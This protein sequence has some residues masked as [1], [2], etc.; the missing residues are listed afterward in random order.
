MDLYPAI[1]LLDGRC[2][3]LYQGDY[4]RSTVYGDDPVAQAL[5]FQSEGAPWVHVVDL[6]AAR[7]GEP[8][9]R[10]VVAAIAGALDVP[11]QTGGGVRTVEAAE[12]LFS[13][14]VAR[15]V[16]GTAALEDPDLVRR[17]AADHPVA[18]GLDARGSEVAVRGWLEGSGADVLDLAV[19]YQDAGVAAL[20]VTEISRDG[21]LE[22][23]DLAGLAA[24]V[25]ATTVPVIASGGIGTLADIEALAALT[26]GGRSL[27]GAI[28]GRAVYEGA[29]TVAQAVA[30]TRGS[31]T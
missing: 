16:L 12:A 3:R 29:F 9:N 24:V 14:G 21:T 18:V 25:A 4:D 27:A 15:V 2:V 26:A 22:G 20:V 1:D 11:V 23:P 10:D 28:T 17:L 19:A 31:A 13:A 8:R 30:V 5:A 6:D 7:T